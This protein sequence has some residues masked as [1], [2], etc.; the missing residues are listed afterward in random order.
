VRSRAACIFSG[1]GVVAN[2][3][4]DVVAVVGVVLTAVTWPGADGWVEAAGG[5]EVDGNDADDVDDANVAGEDEA[6]GVE[7][8]LGTVRIRGRGGAGRVPH[9]YGR[10]MYGRLVTSYGRCSRHTGCTGIR[11]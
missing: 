3:K 10:P 6:R 11:P 5:V 9:G 8:G 7:V 4:A 2:V 1:E